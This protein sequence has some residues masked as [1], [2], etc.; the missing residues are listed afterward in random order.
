MTKVQ[1]LRSGGVLLPV[2]TVT[3]RI[4]TI[5]LWVAL[6]VVLITIPAA[7][8]LQGEIAK[9]LAD[10]LTQDRAIGDPATLP[11]R[12]VAVLSGAA[13]LMAL[14]IAFFT[15]LYRIAWSVQAGDPFIPENAVRLRRM[16]WL[17]LATEAASV[18]L[19]ITARALLPFADQGGGGIEISV[20]GLIAILALFILARVFELG[21]QMRA[22]IEGTV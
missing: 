17:F 10:G 22:E 7:I 2:A 13:M 18:V 19:G 8:V 3:V 9:V 5:V 1:E 4:I 20:T 15:L 6:G 12:I 11:W 21:T 16:A 14:T